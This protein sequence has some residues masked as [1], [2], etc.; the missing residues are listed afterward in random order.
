MENLK[1]AELK[2]GLYQHYKGNIYQVLG[3]C[4]HAETLEI[5]VT[6]QSLYGDYGLWVRPLDLFIGTVEENGQIVPRFK[7]IRPLLQEPPTLR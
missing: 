7:F 3:L 5:L 6:Y 2:L 1:M 4:R